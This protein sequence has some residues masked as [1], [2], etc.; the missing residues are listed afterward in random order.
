MFDNLH[1]TTKVI[2]QGVVT[3]EWFNKQGKLVA[4]V[5]YEAIQT[6]NSVYGQTWVWAMSGQRGAYGPNKPHFLENH[7]EQN[8][9]QNQ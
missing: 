1:P 8:Y 2:S 5:E 6:Y 3:K 9:V 4:T 7:T